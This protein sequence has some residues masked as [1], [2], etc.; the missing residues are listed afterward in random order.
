MTRIMTSTSLQLIRELVNM[1]SRRQIIVR[2]TIKKFSGLVYKANLD[3]PRDI[4]DDLRGKSILDSFSG[5]I[6]DMFYH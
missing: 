6:A 4:D 1:R 2:S 3:L 5:A